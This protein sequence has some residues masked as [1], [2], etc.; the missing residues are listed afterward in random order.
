[1]EVTQSG[2]W[3]ADSWTLRALW[4]QAT[5]GPEALRDLVPL[6]EKAGGDYDT[7][8][9]RS[10]ADASPFALSVGGAKRDE[11]VAARPGR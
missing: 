10:V 4:A 2:D 11:L 6:V 1:M 7:R 5:E 8:S 9:P 3:S